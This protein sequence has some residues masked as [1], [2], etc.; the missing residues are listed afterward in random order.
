[1]KI[2]NDQLD[3]T[4]VKDNQGNPLVLYHGTFASFDTF[5][6]VYLQSLGFHFGDP[7]QANHF[8]E[9]RRGSRIIPVFLLIRHLINIRPSDAGWLRPKQ[10]AICL[11][12][13]NYLTFAEAAKIVGSNHLSL[14][15]HHE[16][17]EPAIRQERNRQIIAALEAKGFDGI[18]Y[19]N[20]QEPGDGVGR[21]AYLVFHATQ[22]FSAI[23]RDCLSNDA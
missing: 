8:A 23:T 10:T 15:D 11:Q 20:K 14:A 9:Q 4:A 21:S 6:D 19:T 13:N 7:V 5:S 3:E 16:L 18:V 22:I 17:E 1:M 2:T 12:I